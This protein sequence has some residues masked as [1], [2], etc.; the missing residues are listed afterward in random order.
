M[1]SHRKKRWMPVAVLV[2]AGLCAAIVGGVALLGGPGDVAD[3]SEG[4][5][6]AAVSRLAASRSGGSASALE[7]AADSDN[8]SVRRAAI[9]GL[10]HHARPSSRE[11][12]VRATKD[13]NAS[14]RAVAADTLGQYKDAR[15]ADVLVKMIAK[16]P[17]ESARLAAIRGLAKCDDP[18]AIVT[19]LELADSGESRAVRLQAMRFLVWKFK[20]NVRALRNPDD[21]AMW[22]DL[23]QRW[24]WDRRVRRAYAAAG[25]KIV[26]RPED[27]VGKDY[28]PERR[29]YD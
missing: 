6:V 26:D 11:V 23:I 13:D 4:D 7:R 14:V 18:R 16:D 9:A 19:L 3:A 12:V 1:S 17:A 8:V 29:T 10:A 28:H 5:R 22:K 24:K 2:G 21:E 27:V 20:G 25:V 15:A